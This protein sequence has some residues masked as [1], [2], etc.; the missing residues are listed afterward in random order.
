MST[1]HISTQFDAELEAIRTSMLRMGGLVEEQLRDALAGFETRDMAMLESV[2]AKEQEVN[3]L[4][5][6]LDDRCTHVVAR[7]QPAAGDLRLVM[8]VFKTIT[9]LERIGDESVKIARAAQRIQARSS[10]LPSGFSG[11]R[12]AGNIAGG[13]LKDALNAF[14]RIDPDAGGKIVLQDA[15][16]DEEFR[17][18][19]RELVT[20]MLEDPKTI[21]T[22]L[23]IIWIGKALERIGDH[24][25]N[26]AQ[27][28]IYI[29]QGVDVRHR[30]SLGRATP[31]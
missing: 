21:S 25:K 11:M 20:F 7:R 17:R 15:Q 27:H 29:A 12:V 13:M 6:D 2:E 8:A 5:I 30:K 14:A 31:T 24:A 3:S 10:S 18:L 9:D 1:H 19:L 26:I 4:E 23:D 22:C 28:V 16:M